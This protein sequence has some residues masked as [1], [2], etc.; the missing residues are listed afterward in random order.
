MARVLV[1][2]PAYNESES[3]G[4]VLAALSREAPEYD[5]VVVNDGSSDHTGEIV[6]A[7]GTA[8]LLRLPYNLGI[9][10][11][12]QTGYKY[13]LREDYDIAV[14]C[15]ADGQHPVH[16]ISKLVD[17][18]ADGTA[19]LIIGSRYVANSD[20]RPSLMRR[21]GKS[22]LSLLVDSAVGGGVTDTT[23]GFRAAN[24]DVIAAFAR[25]YPDDY[26]EPEAL[27]LLHKRGLRSAEVPVDMQPRQ[28]GVSSI[29]PRRAPYYIVKVSLAIF[30]GGFKKVT[31][32][33]DSERDAY[34]E[35]K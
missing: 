28:G 25:H 9:G 1:I 10:A 3:I 7:S 31:H 21:I 8:T 17:R 35:E 20:Y 27:V 11:A 24:R 14:Q 23:S 33:P 16:Q 32:A 12:M 15:D 26:P 29:N 5:V 30:V 6:R 19:D 22:L 34:P 18:V 13:A 4:D 2:V